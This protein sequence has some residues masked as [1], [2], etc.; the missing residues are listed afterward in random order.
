MRRDFG[1]YK[2]EEG[3][4]L[5]QRLR[6]AWYM[7]HPVCGRPARQCTC[8]EGQTGSAELRSGWHQML[9]SRCECNPWEGRFHG[10]L[11]L[12]LQYEARLTAAQ[13]SDKQQKKKKIA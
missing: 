4:K 8:P 12:L 7:L 5:E 9:K 11:R 3:R 10:Q 1:R 2:E 13:V 6:A